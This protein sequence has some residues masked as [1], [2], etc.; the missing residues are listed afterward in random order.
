MG[1]A[2]RALL[3]RLV[4]IVLF[5]VIQVATPVAGCSLGKGGPSRHAGSFL[6]MDQLPIA[7]PPE[8][9]I[10]AYEMARQDRSSMPDFIDVAV[11]FS[12]LVDPEDALAAAHNLLPTP[13]TAELYERLGVA[14]L[15]AARGVRLGEELARAHD[16]LHAARQAFG[17][18]DEARNGD[19]KQRDAS[20][21]VLLHR[22]IV[23]LE[24]ILVAD[25]EDPWP[26]TADLLARLQHR[27]T[28]PQATW[29]WRMLQDPVT[30][31]GEENI[32]FDENLHV[33]G[34]VRAPVKIFAPSPRY[35][36]IARKARVQGVVIIQAVIDRHGS[37]AGLKVLKGLPMGL[38]DEALRAMATWLFEPATLYDQPVA[39]FYN[40]TMNFRL[41]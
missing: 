7:S 21:T 30:Y 28:G 11:D 2:S 9:R 16:H 37:V 25:S 23:G 18:A 24:E 38:D 4:P 12:S 35:P 17:L 32:R 15:S 40:L 19:A 6:T 27:S 22:A 20:G 1:D 13:M 10:A 31:I 39:V 41:R 34:D 26:E 29:A 33:G 3:C 5:S 36:P 8:E 14:L